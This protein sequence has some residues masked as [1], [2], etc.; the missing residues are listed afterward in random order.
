MTEL[1]EVQAKYIKLLEDKQGQLGNALVG[2]EEL[3]KDVE[4]KQEH[5]DR[6]T[7]EVRN[8][9]GRAEK[10]E[11]DLLW[12]KRIAITLDGAE[13]LSGIARQVDRAENIQLTWGSS[14][15]LQFEY[16]DLSGAMAVKRC[17]ATV[18]SWHYSQWSAS[19]LP[20]LPITIKPVQK[21]GD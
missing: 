7:D 5:I 18:D 10:A 9:E 17:K 12:F 3:Q 13:V 6:L 15:S 1:E 8:L 2:T 16:D 19:A 4:R 20:D 14:V 11:G 21:K